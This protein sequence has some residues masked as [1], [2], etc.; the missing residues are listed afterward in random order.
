M[1]K[2]CDIGEAAKLLHKAGVLAYPTESVYGLGCDPRQLEAVQR[3][4]DL[5]GRSH[6]K[7]L[8]LIAA[9]IEQ[10]LPWVRDREQLNTARSSWPGPVTWVFEAA[11]ETPSLLCQ[12]DH[13]I[14]IR[15]TDHPVAAALCSAFGGALVSTSANPAG[16]P[17]ARDQQTIER[18]FDLQLDGLVSGALGG[19][20]QPS[21]IRDARSGH[22]IRHSES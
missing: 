17:P 12:A 18:Y 16:Q 10:V 14:A 21:E 2:R 3:I 13:S 6:Q 11:A 5:K 9:S 4:L 1:L 15:V 7:G 20:K 8:I 22:T 19:R